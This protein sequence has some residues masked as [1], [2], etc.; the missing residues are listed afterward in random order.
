MTDSHWS[1]DASAKAKD[2]YAKLYIDWL[3][4]AWLEALLLGIQSAPPSAP[5]PQGAEAEILE[6]IIDNSWIMGGYMVD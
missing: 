3:G 1:E 6:S 5:P 4:L 2:I